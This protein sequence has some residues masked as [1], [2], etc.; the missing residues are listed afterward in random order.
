MDSTTKKY[1]NRGKKTSTKYLY[2]QAFAHQG[3]IQ[4]HYEKFKLYN[5]LLKKNNEL[6]KEND[7]KIQIIGSR[8][9]TIYNVSKRN[10]NPKQFDFHINT[11]KR[12]LSKQRNI[13]SLLEK[14]TRPF[15][16]TAKTGRTYIIKPKSNPNPKPKTNR[17]FTIKPKTNRTFT[18]KPI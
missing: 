17:T 3:Q 2:R 8:T 15:T 5:Q 4:K 6:L 14:I 18:I 13:N 16:H 11:S 7:N 9:G 10:K 1:I 12:K